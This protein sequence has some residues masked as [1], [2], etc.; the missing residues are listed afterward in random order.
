MLRFGTS[1]A[2]KLTGRQMI[3]PGQRGPMVGRRD[4]Q[5]EIAAKVNVGKAP[6]RTKTGQGYSDPNDANCRV[7]DWTKACDRP[8]SIPRTSIAASSTTTF[9]VTPCGPYRLGDD[10][11]RVFIM[12]PSMAALFQFTSISVCREDYIEDDPWPAEAFVANGPGVVIGCGSVFFPALPLSVTVGNISN[13]AATF[14][15]LILGKELSICG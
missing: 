5:K 13:A 15:M 6:T 12:P 11:N 10:Q 14:A 7:Y 8:I 9:T 4:I 3:Q 2:V 1:S